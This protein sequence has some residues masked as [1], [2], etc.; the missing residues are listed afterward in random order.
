MAKVPQGHE[1]HRHDREVM[2]P[3]PGRVKLEVHSTSV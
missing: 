2:G 3:N 1:M